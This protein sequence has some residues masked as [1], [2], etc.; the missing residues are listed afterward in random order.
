MSSVVERARRGMGAVSRGLRLVNN[1]EIQ[2]HI[3]KL[4]AGKDELG[5]MD[6]LLR[7]QLLLP[8][9]RVRHF[10][11]SVTNRVVPKW[12]LPRLP[13]VLMGVAASGVDVLE[14]I[15]QLMRENINNTQEALRE[16]ASAA[17][18]TFN[19][20]TELN[21]DIERAQKENWDARELQ[22]YIAERAGVAVYE[23][24]AELLDNE[25]S[26][27]APEVREE[28]KVELLWQLHSNVEVGK[29]LMNTMN[30]VCAAGLQIFHG[31]VGRY[32]DY[33]R[34]Y[35]PIAVIRDAARTMIETNHG[36]IASREALRATFE[37]SVKAIELVLDS[38]KMAE[39]YAVSS[40]D[41]QRALEDNRM[42]I[43]KKLAEFGKTS[44]QRLL[45]VPKQA[46]Q[47]PPA[48]TS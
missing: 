10:V 40:P 7:N 20:F 19:E 9:S 3:K 18:R 6:S 44:G 30:E 5:R 25:F 17:Q 45:V 36:G 46:E 35:Q 22:A 2:E 13:A 24:V 43:H 31:A 32:Y 29:T 37:E 21:D 39:N 15:E 47:N 26:S 41:T 11:G 42:R 27:L 4:N 38:A 28:R 1:K 12:L 33:V 16:L 34:T 48:T 8:T 14:T 23:E